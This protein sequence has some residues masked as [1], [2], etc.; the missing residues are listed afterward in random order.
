V[1]EIIKI[2]FYF[3]SLWTSTSKTLKQRRFACYWQWWPVNLGYGLF[4][5]LFDNSCSSVFKSRTVLPLP[6]GAV[7]LLVGE[8]Q[9]ELIWKFRHNLHHKTSWTCVGYY[10]LGHLTCDQD[11]TQSLHPWNCTYVVTQLLWVELLCWSKPL[12]TSCRSKIVKICCEKA[13]TI[14]WESS[15]MMTDSYDSTSGRPNQS[16]STLIMTNDSK[17]WMKFTLYLWVQQVSCIST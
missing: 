11:Q 3:S 12:A 8:I 5:D 4:W 1:I 7:L 10:H 16:A 2:I 17:I 14:T 9:I 6:F 15:I 13:P